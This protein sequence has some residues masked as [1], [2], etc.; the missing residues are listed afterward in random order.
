MNSRRTIQFYD[1]RLVRVVPDACDV[2]GRAHRSWRANRGQIAACLARRCPSNGHGPDQGSG[3]G[4]PDEGIT[5]REHL[6][7]TVP[8]RA[9]L[10]LGHID[11]NCDLPVLHSQNSALGEQA[12]RPLGAA[13]HGEVVQAP[14]S[15]I[16]SLSAKPI[17]SHAQVPLGRINVVPSSRL[18]FRLV[19][20]EVRIPPFLTM[21]A[22]HD[23]VVLNSR[24]LSL[25]ASAAE[26]HVLVLPG[27][28]LPSLRAKLVQCLGQ[29]PQFHPQPSVRFVEP[30]DFTNLLFRQAAEVV[31]PQELELEQELSLLLAR[32]SSTDGPGLLSLTLAA[33]REHARNERKREQMP[34]T[35]ATPAG[36]TDGSGG[37]AAGVGFRKLVSLEGRGG[38][39]VRGSSRPRARY[40]VSSFSAR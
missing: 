29:V 7:K 11:A 4:T 15:D 22:M 28:D 26:E 10:D 27:H 33:G 24:A 14:H 1:H 32:D 13:Q 36:F 23:G 9:V 31:M 5:G 40:L 18:A 34:G 35:P 21:E 2:L 12:L 37:V 16:P 8:L 6:P 39:Q 25:D 20:E 3:E 19:L 30:V 38:G 17:Q